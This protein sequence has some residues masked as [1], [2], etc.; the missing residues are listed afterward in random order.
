MPFRRSSDRS[1]RNFSLVF[2]LVWGLGLILSLSLTV[3]IIYFLFQAAK[4]LA[5]L[6]A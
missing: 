4:Y 5:K 2:F 3:T 6:A 1:L